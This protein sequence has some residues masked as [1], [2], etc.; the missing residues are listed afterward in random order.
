[1]DKV[2]AAFQQSYQSDLPRL[3]QL[4]ESRF[5]RFAEKRLR[6]EVFLLP[7]TSVDDFRDAFR[8]AL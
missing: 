8:E 1:M 4:L 7:F 2:I 3:Q 5:S 6:F